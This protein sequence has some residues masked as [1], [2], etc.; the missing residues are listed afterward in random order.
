MNSAIRINDARP[1]WSYVQWGKEIQK[2]F[3]Y[4]PIVDAAIHE[5]YFKPPL[6]GFAASL[7]S[8]IWMLITISIGKHFVPQHNQ[9]RVRSGGVASI[10]YLIH[11]RHSSVNPKA[12]LETMVVMQ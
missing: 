8:V 1:S 6:R 12:S 11:F 9:Q 4:K 2:S 5:A 10:V 3:P 7:Y